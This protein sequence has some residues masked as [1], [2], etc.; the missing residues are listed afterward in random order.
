MTNL[1]RDEIIIA[2]L[3]RQQVIDI[4]GTDAAVLALDNKDCDFTGSLRHDDLIE[5]SATI[6]LDHDDFDTLTAYYYQDEEDVH[7]DDYE[8][9]DLEWKVAFYKL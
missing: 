5:F 7:N 1:T 4:L 8:L 9:D 6:D 2:E 3:T